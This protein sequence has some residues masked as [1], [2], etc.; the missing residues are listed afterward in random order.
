MFEMCGVSDQIFWI[1]FLGNEAKSPEIDNGISQAV[2]NSDKISMM[3]SIFGGRLETTLTAEKSTSFNRN[4]INIWKNCSCFK[5][6]PCDFPT[7]KANLPENSILY[8]NQT[9]QSYKDNKKLFY[10]DYYL[11]GQINQCLN[12]PED[13]KN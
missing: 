10:A 2:R 6:Q 8:I 13:L 5:Q 9:Y 3:K 11:L 7:E 4:I 1:F 12:P